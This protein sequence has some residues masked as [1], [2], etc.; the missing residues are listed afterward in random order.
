MGGDQF[1]AVL[2][3][4]RRGGDV[5]RLLDRIAAAFLEHPFRLNEAVFRIAAR[6]GGA[7]FPDD[8][9]DADTLYRNAEAALKRAKKDGERFLFYTQGMTEAVAGKLTM[10]SQLREA[11]AKG[12]FVLHYQPKVNLASGRITGT[13]ALI[14]WNDPTNGAGAADAVH[15]DPRG[16]RADP[17]RRTL[18]ARNGHRRLPALEGRRACPRCASR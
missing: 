1:A 13:E 17:R 6:A 14:R 7:L 12:E 11:L 3:E 5:S 9:A 15:P 8:G 10:E 16:D 4:V 18:G 2:P